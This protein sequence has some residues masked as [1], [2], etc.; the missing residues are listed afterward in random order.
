MPG[1]YAGPRSAVP[2]ESA[3]PRPRLVRP[4]SAR[5][6][7]RRGGPPRA[8]WDRRAGRSRARAAAARR[9]TSSGRRRRA[10]SRAWRGRHV[11]PDL[12]AG[13]RVDGIDAVRRAEVHDAVD[14]HRRRGEAAG[15]GVERP[16]ALEIRDVARVDLRQRRE[17]RAGR[18]ALGGWPIAAGRT[19]LL[20]HHGDSSPRRR[21]PP[22]SAHAASRVTPIRERIGMTIAPRIDAGPVRNRD[23]TV[24]SQRAVRRTHCLL[25]LPVYAHE[26]NDVISPRPVC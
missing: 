15:P 19:G 10:V 23:D 3:P 18:V 14:D 1:Q 16:G 24:N 21:S 11:F 12:L 13:H 7:R 20:R 17:A 6:L 22:R 4:G 9:A 25:I 2:A 8:A 5:P 26:K